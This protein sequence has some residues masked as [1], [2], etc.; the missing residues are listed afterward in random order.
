MRHGLQCTVVIATAS[1]RHPTGTSRREAYHRP[2]AQTFIRAEAVIRRA[3]G[4][5]TLRKLAAG[6]GVSHETIRAVARQNLLAT[7]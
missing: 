2:R 1:D 3:V 5:R 6:F 4:N 7:G